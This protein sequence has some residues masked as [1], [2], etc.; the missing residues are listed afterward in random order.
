M[1]W[2]RWV[3]FGRV[4]P[5]GLQLGVG[6]SLGEMWESGVLDQENYEEA[7]SALTAAFSQKRDFKDLAA[8]TE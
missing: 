4:E 1:V 5:A 6:A 2:D 3:A 7:A 8:R